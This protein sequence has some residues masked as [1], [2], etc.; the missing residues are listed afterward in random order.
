[1]NVG[2]IQTPDKNSN[3]QSAT[4]ASFPLGSSQ[5]SIND[6]SNIKG[7][8]PAYAAPHSIT[9][10]KI[11]DEAAEPKMAPPPH[12]IS[13]PQPDAAPFIP[14]GYS[15]SLSEPRFGS[16]H[17]VER[18][19]NPALR[20][21][22]GT[23]AGQGQ[24]TQYY[25][26]KHEEHSHPSLT[27]GNHTIASTT[28]HT[29]SVASSAQS[30]PPT[31]PANI[32]INGAV[33]AIHPTLVS[34][35]TP[36]HPESFPP[37]RDSY[38][39]PTHGHEAFTKPSGPT[40]RAVPSNPDP[41][42]FFMVAAYLHDQFGNSELADC[43]LRVTNTAHHALSFQLPVHALILGRSP[44]FRSLLK[45]QRDSQAEP[46]KDVEIDV[47][48][49]FLVDHVAFLK[50]M[51]R[52]YAGEL[53]DPSFP[54]SILG[55]R[56]EKDSMQFA[57]SY[58]AAGHYLQ[59]DEIIGRGLDMVM[60]Y[61]SFT[62]LSPA[63]AFALD[64]GLGPFWH[65]KNSHDDDRDS[66]TSSAEDSNHKP[67]SPI[68]TP[69]Y[70][71]Y[72]DKLLHHVLGFVAHH[73]RSHFVFDAKATELPDYPRLPKDSTRRV[74]R[75][76]SRLT[77]IRFGEMATNDEE[78]QRRFTETMSSVLLSLP[79]QPLKQL[80]EFG[81]HANKLDSKYVAGLM[82]SVVEER[83]RRRKAAFDRYNLKDPNLTLDDRQWRTLQWCEGVEQSQR[84]PCG[85]KLYRHRLGAGT[86]TSGKS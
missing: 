61:L 30:I 47:A 19:H 78:P 68:L 1:M 84:H 76:N 44:K 22:S 56:H 51:R 37:S 21:D 54:S 75:P 43:V 77:Q 67:G 86:P 85:Y 33:K 81:I 83:E 10:Q 27:P 7:A 20:H 60:H 4:P 24:A 59:I 32:H 31:D 62:T 48:D 73:L 40:P 12:P 70:G 25:D 49:R 50:A 39:V 15:Y 36:S 79:Y 72:G 13:A 16:D 58:A 52:L 6:E 80:L 38:S 82:E 71:I 14:N 23:Q 41:S 2:N 11:Q 8:Q 69:T 3:P 26:T 28:S 66:S 34:P 46:G 64:G 53:P 65:S 45:M 35:T 57:L 17:A 63:L 5:P 74:S 42:T 18:S 55:Y 29:G 9:P